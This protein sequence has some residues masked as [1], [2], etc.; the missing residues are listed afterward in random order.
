MSLLYVKV[1]KGC[2]IHYCDTRFIILDI[3]QYFLFV[4]FQWNSLLRFQFFALKWKIWINRRRETRYVS[5]RIMK[6]LGR[7]TLFDPKK[8]GLLA[9]QQAYQNNWL[10]A[11]SFILQEGLKFPKN[12]YLVSSYPDFVPIK[13]ANISFKHL[14]QSLNVALKQ[15]A[16]LSSVSNGF[17]S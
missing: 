9:F 16:Q 10:K 17:V 14:L 13:N 8:L 5:N 4:I 12:L 15:S 7:F 11:D 3:N 1:V 2:I 6:P